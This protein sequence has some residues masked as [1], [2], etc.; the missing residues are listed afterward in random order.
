MPTGSASSARLRLPPN[1]EAQVRTSPVFSHA[2]SGYN[3]VIS[4]YNEFHTENGHSSAREV[5]GMYTEPPCVL[6]T[7]DEIWACQ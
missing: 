3:A 4:V 2:D 7:Y 5:V 6:R 1:P